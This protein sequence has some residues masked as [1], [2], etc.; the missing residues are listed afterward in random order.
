MIRSGLKRRTGIRKVNPKRKASRMER[1]Y[2]G[3]KAD[4]IR[5]LPCCVPA[6]ETGLVIVAA[7]ARSRGAGGHADS[8]VSMCAPHHREQHDG[9]KTFEAKYGIN[10]LA[11][12]AELEARWQ[13]EG[14][15]SE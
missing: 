5:S 15:G 6:C 12:A 10:L 9:I 14:K 11:L 1:D 7:H 4:W 13:T 3:P 8:L 2:G